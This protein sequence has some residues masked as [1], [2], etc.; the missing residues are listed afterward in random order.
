MSTERTLMMVKPDAV[1]KNAIGQ[2]LARVEAEGFVIRELRMVR[3]ARERAEGFYA[4][5]QE[6]PFF[7]ELIQ[8]M[9]SG[10]AVPM[11]LER[12]N[13]V[14]HLRAFIGATDSTQAAPETI[15]RDFGTDVQRNAVHASDSPGNAAQEIAFFF[16]NDR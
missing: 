8:F 4:V 1:G 14:A 9:I 15:R 11:V 12:E 6:R 10:P 2:I 13:A 16:G 3:L 5:H 7:G